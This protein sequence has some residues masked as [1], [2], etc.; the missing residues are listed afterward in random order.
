[1]VAILS[2]QDV[3]NIMGLV[4]IVHGRFKPFDTGRFLFGAFARPNRP[5]SSISHKYKTPPARTL[6]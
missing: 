3:Q 6:E 2:V 1:M 5:K 4:A